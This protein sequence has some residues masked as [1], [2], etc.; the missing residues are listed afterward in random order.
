[1]CCSVDVHLTKPNWVIRLR[2]CTNCHT[3]LYWSRCVITDYNGIHTTDNIMCTN[4]DCPLCIQCIVRTNNCLLLMITSIII[5]PKY[6]RL[7]CRDCTVATTKDDIIVTINRIITTNNDCICTIDTCV[8]TNGNTIIA[9]HH[10][11]YGRWF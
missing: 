1:M 7:V 11:I 3:I 4:G 10:R 9:T 8:C 2:I 5:I 6:S